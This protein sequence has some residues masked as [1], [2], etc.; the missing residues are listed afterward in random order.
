MSGLESAC[1]QE[2]SRSS[3]PGGRHRGGPPGAVPGPVPRPVRVLAVRPVGA[4][5]TGTCVSRTSA[6]RR[7]AG[8]T[9]ESPPPCSTG[10][11]VARR[12]ARRGTRPGTG[13]SYHRPTF[14]SFRKVDAG[15]LS[16]CLACRRVVSASRLLRIVELPQIRTSTLDSDRRSPAIAN[17]RD[18]FVRR[19]R[20][21]FAFGVVTVL[22]LRRWSKVFASIVE[23]VAV[24][25]ID[26]RIIRTESKNLSR[27]DHAAT[28]IAAMNTPRF[29]T[30]KVNDPGVATERT[31]VPFIDQNEPSAGRNPSAAWYRSR[32]RHARSSLFC[33][34]S[35]PLSGRTG[36]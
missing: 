15:E 25:V 10:V 33:D 31:V 17:L 32:L 7:R 18:A 1:R 26:F 8:T 5:R 20:V 22:T 21:T 14:S 28:V 27:K 3:S 29:A 24:S 13:T 23:R 2:R 4:P 6:S 30:I 34:A 9:R 16:E 36:T 12:P 35:I 11:R 19:N